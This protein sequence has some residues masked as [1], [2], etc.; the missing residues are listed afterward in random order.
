MIQAISGF[1]LE[2]VSDID[3]ARRFYVDLLGLVVERQHPTYVQFS[4][5]AIASDESLSGTRELE[6]YWLVDDAD[7]A[8]AELRGKAEVC[9]PLEQKPYGKVFGVKNPD[10]RPC[11][12]VEFARDR[13]S[14]PA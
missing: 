8:Y 11:Y 13:P 7:A 14:R 1:T 3:K 9:Q 12:V 10:G 2:Y 6:T 5:F 4:H